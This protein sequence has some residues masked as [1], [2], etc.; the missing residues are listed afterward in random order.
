MKNF[1]LEEKLQ[2]LITA[3]L[4]KKLAGLNFLKDNQWNSA[5][6]NKCNPGIHVTFV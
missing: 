6:K 1:L 3:Y 2:V 4:K 5:L